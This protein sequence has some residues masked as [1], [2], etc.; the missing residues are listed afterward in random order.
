[1]ND[2]IKENFRLQNNQQAY[3]VRHNFHARNE[4]DPLF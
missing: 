3:F 2:L 4:L 1:M